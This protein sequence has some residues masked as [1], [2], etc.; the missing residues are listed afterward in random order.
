MIYWCKNS[1][2]SFTASY[3]DE[4]SIWYFTSFRENS[5]Y[6]LGCSVIISIA[7]SNYLVI[8]DSITIFLLNSILVMYTL[9]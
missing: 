4:F 5:G 7:V 8:I 2:S 3:V 9:L 6:L 1:Y